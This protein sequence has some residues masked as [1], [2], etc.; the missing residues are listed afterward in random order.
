MKGDF[1]AFRRR[2]GNMVRNFCLLA[3]DNTP[4][5]RVGDTH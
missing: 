3:I 5:E 4:V 2:N 1:H